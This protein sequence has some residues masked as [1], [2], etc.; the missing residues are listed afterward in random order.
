MKKSKTISLAR[1]KAPLS[2]AQIILF[3]FAGVILLGALLLMLPFSTADGKGASFSDAIFTSTSAT[4]VTGL[5][6]QDTATYWS[7]FGKSV[8]I[9]LIQIGGMGVVT[10]VSLFLLIAGKRIGLRQR[11]ILQDSL[12]APKVGGIVKMMRFI[13]LCTLC[14]ELCGAVFLSFSLCPRFGMI[15]GI[16]YSLFHSISAF[17]NAGFD[18]MGTAEAQYVS[19]TGFASDI[20][21]NS[22]LMLLI[23]AGGIGFLTWE[24]IAI[25]K[26]HFRKY[27]M[28]TKA[29]LILSV[30]LIFLPAVYFFFFEFSDKPMDERILLS[31]F[32]SV[33]ARTAGFNTA[34]LTNLTEVG[35]A[36][37]IMLMLVGGSS[38]STAGGMKITTLAVLLASA[39]DAFKRRDSAAM[40]GRRI[41]DD[42]E[43]SAV[44]ILIMYIFLFVFGGCAISIIEGLPLL[45]CLFET[46]SAVATV[47]LTL[48]VTP[49]FC[50]A[51]Q[52]IL[53][54]LMFLGRI[55]GLTL[56]FAAMSKNTNTMSKY[57][58][59]KITVG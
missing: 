56:V 28:Q 38:G 30:L 49:T 36:V 19:M 58:E 20:W 14:I 42:T 51:S 26:H 45:T 44:T 27:H 7:L 34:D 25:H 3:G 59:E 37:M 29:V 46:A 10:V 43:R 54:L 35:T 41:D 12:S 52:I 4:C 18:L 6:V 39:R 32:Q 57:P 48:G 13:V 24:D 53:I 23:I 16:I 8:I 50:I 31:L 21:V 40:F 33:T 17:C 55:G 22:V 11:S 47:G 15:K 5:V 2:S 1:K 9:C